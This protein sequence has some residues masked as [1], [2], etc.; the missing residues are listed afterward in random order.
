MSSLAFLHADAPG[1][2]AA[3]SS[4]AREAAAAGARFETR[5]GWEV[6]TSY[7]GAK[8]E[9]QAIRE[10]VGFADVSHLGTLELQGD[11][12]SVE[13]VKLECGT[14]VRHDD[15]WWCAVT[16]DRALIVCAPAATARLRESLTASF[17]GHVLDVTA[18]YGGLAIAGPL[19]RETFARFC[20]LDLRPSVTP[21]AGFRP[22]SVARTPGYVLREAPERYLALFGSAVGSYVWE[23]V[24]DA[25]THL[26]GRA[27]GVD[28]LAE[29]APVAEEVES[30]A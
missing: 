27:V 3:V 2:A 26:G 18:V 16:P 9:Q 6:A 23:V 1:G 11:L 5:D 22:G 12:G 29:A 21:V 13:G 24:A 7:A 20:A 28:A 8:V 19:A 14:A 15:A 17:K 10:T 25:A 4:M 30:H